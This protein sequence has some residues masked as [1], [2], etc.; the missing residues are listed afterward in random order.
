M[1]SKLGY[2]FEFIQ[3]VFWDLFPL[4]FIMSCDFEEQ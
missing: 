3:K 4:I 2:S 1:Y